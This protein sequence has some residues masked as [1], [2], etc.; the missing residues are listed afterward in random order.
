MSMI[1]TATSNLIDVLIHVATGAR[2]MFMIQASTKSHVSTATRHHVNI[3]DQSIT[4]RPCWCPLSELQSRTMLISLIFAAATCSCC[5]WRLCYFQVTY[6]FS[7]P[8][9]YPWSLLPLEMML[10]FL[11]HASTSIYADVTDPF[12]L[13]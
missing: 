13:Y 12:Y 11:A 7:K 6:W 2:W 3:L 4:D 1:P 9:W 8:C 5:H 10:M